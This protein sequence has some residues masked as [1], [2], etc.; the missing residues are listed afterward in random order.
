MNATTHTLSQLVA[1]PPIHAST[2]T[3]LVR[4]SAMR[5]NLLAVAYPENTFGTPTG[6]N[7]HHPP[8]R[9]LADV[10]QL[11]GGTILG[12]KVDLEGAAKQLEQDL[13]AGL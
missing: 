11:L 8:P 12:S 10:L 9:H 2:M 7:E 13:E 6:Q 3:L 1:S 4:S 5:A